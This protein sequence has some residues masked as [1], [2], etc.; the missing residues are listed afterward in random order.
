MYDLIKIPLAKDELEA[1]RLCD[2]LGRTQKEDGTEMG[3]SRGTV[4]RLVAS[5]HTKVARALV[6]GCALIL[7]ETNMKEEE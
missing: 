2:L 5:A 1:L 6:E 4:Q 7:G 3:V